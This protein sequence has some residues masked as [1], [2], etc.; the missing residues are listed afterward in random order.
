MAKCPLLSRIIQSEP[1]V[2]KKWILSGEESAVS[3]AA[4]N[5]SAA[6]FLFTARCG[7]SRVQIRTIAVIR[8][9]AT[10]GRTMASIFFF[11]IISPVK[12]YITILSF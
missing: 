10:M 2:L 7:T 12:W 6:S 4:G 1:P 11:F 9:A 5:F 3:S 8:M